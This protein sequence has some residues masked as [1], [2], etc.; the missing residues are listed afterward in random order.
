VRIDLH[1][2]SSASDGTQPPAA[3][4]AEAAAAG[5]D[6][7]ALTDHDTTAG[8]P[9]ASGAAR[10]AGIALV[11]GAEISCQ[12]RGISV[13]LLSYLHDPAEPELAAEMERTRT[14]RLTRA[15]RMVDLIALDLPLTWEEVAA[16]VEP[17]ATVGRPHIADAMVA[18]GLVADRDEAFATVL[19][20]GSPYYVRH[21]APDAERAVRLVR[22]AG[23]V[24][25]MAHP[26]AARR[27]RVVSDGVIAGL[28]G[29]G[30]AGLEVDHRDHEPAEREHLR[31]LAAGLGLL[32]TGSS[33]YHGAGKVNRLGENLTSPQTLER[34]EALA[35]GARVVRP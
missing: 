12:A 11:P 13:H 2:H 22:R 34:I 3:V 25:V 27:G 32:T 16:R 14:D 5:L 35:T 28:A 6:V 29:A 20:A 10:R 33:D 23:G 19:H 1:V 18:K 26:L 24:P 7:V 15:R 17:G 21:Y 30:L 9:E 8:W 4:V 31:A